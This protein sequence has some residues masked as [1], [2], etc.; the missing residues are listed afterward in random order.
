MA[1]EHL[2]QQLSCEGEQRRLFKGVKK[3]I[4]VL[5][6]EGAAYGKPV[7]T[8]LLTR[9]RWTLSFS[10]HSQIL[11]SG[12]TQHQRG[13][14]IT[15]MD[16]SY[17]DVA[18]STGI[19]LSFKKPQLSRM[20]GA[21]QNKAHDD[22]FTSQSALLYYHSACLCFDLFKSLFKGCMFLCLWAVRSSQLGECK[23]PLHGVTY[24][25]IVLK[26]PYLSQLCLLHGE[27]NPSWNSSAPPLSTLKSLLGTI[28]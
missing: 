7:F 18:N 10:P 11:R 27:R 3:N 16:P 24:K 5:C 28:G 13:K 19:N 23:P 1:I 21:W 14:K 20:R 22:P 8:T 15:E 9:S 2:K 6:W 25:A 4:R 12:S 26:E 17:K